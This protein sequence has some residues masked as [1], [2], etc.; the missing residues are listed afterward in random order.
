MN[1]MFE[2]P[3]KPRLVRCRD[4]DI[5]VNEMR[6]IG[7][8]TMQIYR[9]IGEVGPVDLDLLYEVLSV[10]RM[11]APPEAATGTSSAPLCFGV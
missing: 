8:D 9:H 4:I 11:R 3:R 10:E 6:K 1:Q 7:M 2:E 5:V